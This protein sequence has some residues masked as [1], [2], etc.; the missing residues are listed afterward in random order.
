MSF[1]LD[2]RLQPLYVLHIHEE[3]M[4]L[5]QSKRLFAE[6]DKLLGREEKFGVV[7]H[8]KF[9]EAHPN[10]DDFDKEFDGN[11]DDDDHPHDPKHKH[12]P[13][14]ARYQKAW[15]TANRDR[16]AQQCVGIA[17]VSANS[18]FVAFYAPLANRIMSRMYRCPGAM[19]GDLD[20]A[21]AWVQARMPQPVA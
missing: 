11:L 6:V 21:M 14:L 15:L 3:H 5:E 2:E 17:I 8:Y 13:G 20:K 4:S 12:E 19:F 16:F 18:K 10:D 9:D 1:T 7:M